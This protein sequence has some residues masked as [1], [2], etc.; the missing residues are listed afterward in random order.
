MFHQEGMFHQKGETVSPFLYVAKVIATTAI[1]KFKVRF[2][3]SPKYLKRVFG[4]Y[5]RVHFFFHTDQITLI[6]FN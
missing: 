2:N 4:E 3:V 6:T 5:L 1:R